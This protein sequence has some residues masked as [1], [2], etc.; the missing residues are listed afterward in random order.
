MPAVVVY[1]NVKHYLLLVELAVVDG[2]RTDQVIPL[3]SLL[4]P[5]LALSRYIDPT[6][7]S[8]HATHDA[9]LPVVS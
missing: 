9:V 8:T 2:H 1:A 6:L 3:S 5:R 7:D 4:Y